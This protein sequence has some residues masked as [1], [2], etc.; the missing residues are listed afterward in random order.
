[1]APRLT[2]LDAA[3]VLATR[4][5]VLARLL[6]DVGPPRLSPLQ[7]THFGALVRSIVYQQLA[8]AAAS[9]IYG[10][11]VAALGGEVVPERILALSEP[12]LFAVGLSKAKAAS[13]GELSA[14]VADGTLV[15]DRR[16]LAKASDEE[17]IEALSAIRGIGPWTAQMFLLFQLRRLD[18]WPTGDLGVRR[19]YGLAWE[20]PMPSASELARLGERFAPFRSVVAWYCWR[21]C[22]LYARAP[23]SALTR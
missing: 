3:R 9:A 6:K 5:E 12:E 19:G 23:K 10:R 18:V 4:D 8:G 20:V 13:L 22:E 11:L 21:A 2:H 15:L 7:P 16:R 14:R 1:M 17:V